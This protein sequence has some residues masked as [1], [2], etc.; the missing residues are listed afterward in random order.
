[1]SS[2][3]NSFGFGGGG[4]S[5]CGCN[6]GGI[7]GGDNIWLIVILLFVF[8]GLGNNNNCGNEC[9][10]EVASGEICPTC[11]QCCN[12]NGI[13]G[14]DNIWLIIIV[15]FLFLSNDNCNT[16]CNTGCNTLESESESE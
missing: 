9:C 12:N 7:L 10:G 4:G 16:G 13:L 14:G 8:G 15:L 11:G 2:L 3:F 6:S 5:N 1:M